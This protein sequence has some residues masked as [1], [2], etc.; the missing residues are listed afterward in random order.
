MSKE[1]Q[2]KIQKS[3]KAKFRPSDSELKK[4]GKKGFESMEKLKP[5]DYGKFSEITDKEI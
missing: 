2:T 3:F 5:E 1:K 4:I